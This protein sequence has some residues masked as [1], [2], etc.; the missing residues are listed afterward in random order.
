[1]V[2]EG[3]VESPA[4]RLIPTEGESNVGHPTADLAPRADPFDLPTSLEEIHGIVVM[5][6]HACSNG[7]YVGVENDVLGIEAHFLHHNS[8]SSLT[9]AYLQM[10]CYGTLEAGSHVHVFTFC[11]FVCEEQEHMLVKLRMI[12]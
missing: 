8:E 1:M 11:M 9:N 7:E 2:Q 5:L 12:E 3:R 4:N 6:R 10:D